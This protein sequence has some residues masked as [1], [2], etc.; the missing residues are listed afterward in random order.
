M[1][2]PKAPYDGAKGP[3]GFR[4]QVKSNDDSLGSTF[5]LHSDSIVKSHRSKLFQ[6]NLSASQIGAFSAILGTFDTR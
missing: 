2:E 6:P 3:L 1:M 5:V 4:V